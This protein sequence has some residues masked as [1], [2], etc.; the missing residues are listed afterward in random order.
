MRCTTRLGRLVVA[1]FLCLAAL[2]QSCE[3]PLAILGP[4]LVRVELGSASGRAVPSVVSAVELTVKADDMDSLAVALAAPSYAASVEV[5]AGKARIFSVVARDATGVARYAGDASLDVKGGKSI[6]LSISLAAV[7]RL[8]YDGNGAASGTAPVDP[9][10]YRAGATA[11]VLGNTGTLAL[12]GRILEGWTENAAGSGAVHKPGDPLTM[13]ASDLTLYAKWVYPTYAITYHLNGGSAHSNPAT[14]T[15]ASLPLTLTPATWGANAFEGWYSDP[16]LAT[17]VASIPAGTTGDI[18]LYAGW[19]LPTISFDPNGGTGSMA[20]QQAPAGDSLTLAS[21]AF[22][23]PGYAPSGWNT[24]S[25]GSGTAYGLGATIT[26]PASDTMLYAQWSANSYTVTFDAQGGSP[27]GTTRSV[28]FGSAY[29]TPPGAART[30][31]TLER[32]N[33]AS[34]GSGTDVSGGTVLSIPSDHTIYAIWTPN[35]YM[36]HFDINGGD[37]GSMA[38]QSITFGTSQSLSANAFSRTG[39]AFAGW[40]TLANGSGTPYANGASFTMS[41]A[42]QTLYAQWNANSY[43]VT[44]DAQGGTGPTPPSQSATF[45][46]PYGTLATTTKAGYAFS[47][48]WTGIGGTGSQAL[49]GT[50]MAIP[51]PQ[52]LYAHWL[53]GFSGGDGSVGTPFEITTVEHLKNVNYFRSSHFALKA[54]LDLAAETNWTPLG[55]ATTNFTG[56]FS[57]ENHTLSNLT[58]NNMFDDDRGLFGVA[59]DAVIKDLNLVGVNFIKTYNDAGALVGQAA[60]TTQI[61]N[62]SA[63]GT[64]EAYQVTGGLVGRALTGGTVSITKCWTNVTIVSRSYGA[65]GGLVG[66]M[67]SGTIDRCYA[68]GSIGLPVHSGGSEWNYIGGLVGWLDA[69]SIAN[70]Y[71]RGSVK[72]SIRVGGLVGYAL[73]GASKS[74]VNCYSTGAVT[75]TSDY[76]GLIGEQAGYTLTSLLYDQATS[77]MSDAGKGTPTSTASLQNASTVGTVYSGWDFATIWQI[78]DGQYPTLR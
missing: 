68:L 64:I 55:D 4:G 63:T 23:R 61:T 39:H 25:N 14:Y 35:D 62:C 77:G 50:T 46:Q 73:N 31:Y 42:G 69:A 3:S 15:E 67:E 21:V 70:S 52:T 34:N 47:G 72:G 22:S 40:N 76:G 44:F 48:W 66:R 24:A 36:V 20:P 2:S 8:T 51:G 30:G 58:I 57:G 29:G 49:P 53:P 32:W 74:I 1:A 65:I 19:I 6:D 13:P 71:A 75:G 38:D 54:D 18:D 26:M 10:Y 43:T 56:S 33:T 27:T 16:G 45:G 41:V 11:T 12:P 7:Y 28:G 9:A 78:V 5:P 37:G 59:T 60:G 17:Y